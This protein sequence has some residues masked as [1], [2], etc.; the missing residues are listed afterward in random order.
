VVFTD[1]KTFDKYAAEYPLVPVGKRIPADTETPVSTYLKTAN[2]PW[3]FLFE[4]VEGGA[5]WGRYSLVGFDPFLILEAR[6]RQ[7]LVKRNGTTISSQ[8]PI[9]EIRSII[10]ENRLPKIEGFPRFAGGMVGYLGYGTARLFEELPRLDEDP[11]NLPDIKLFAPRKLLAFDNARKTLDVIVIADATAPDSYDSAMEEVE[12]ILDKLRRPLPAEIIFPPKS[13]PVSLKPVIPKDKFESMVSQ[14]REA[15]HSGEAIQVV[16]SQPFEGET[17]LDPF[18]VY[19]AL[20][21]LNPSPYL[22]HLRMGEETLVGG[23]PEVMVRVEDGRG[24]V[25]PIA[26]TR[27][28]G[29]NLAE[30]LALEKELLADAK[31]RAEHVMLVDLGRN[32]LGRVAKPGAVKLEESFIVERYSH[33]MHLVSTVSADLREGVDCLDVFGATFP[34][35]TVSGAP[36]VR[37]MELIAELEPRERGYYAGAVGYVGFDGNLDTC[38]A[39]RTMLFHEGKVYLQAGAGIVADSDPTK[40]YEETLHKARALMKAL[41]VAAKGLGG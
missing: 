37:A 20:R 32:D 34:A 33:V 29:A 2:A 9:A 18:T 16:L 8:D 1:R 30:D 13:K 21:T 14:V 7:A 4:S 24:L 38:I 27:H 22:F 11:V 31:E 36:K 12:E 15:I 28:R 40:E 35:G 19:R 41:E 17:D 26:G 6:G 25:R 10:A 5:Q 23:S 39:I 3:S